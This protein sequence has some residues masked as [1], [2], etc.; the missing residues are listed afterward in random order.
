MP[1]GRRVMVTSELIPK[2][3]WL[4]PLSADR[5]RSSLLAPGNSSAM[6]GAPCWPREAAPRQWDNLAE[7]SPL[8]S[9]SAGHEFINTVSPAHVLSDKHRTRRGVIPS[10][11]PL[12]FLSAEILKR[13]SGKV[14]SLLWSPPR[15]FWLSASSCSQL[16]PQ[17]YYKTNEHRPSRGCEPPG[18]R[19]C[20]QSTLLAWPA[21]CWTQLVT[22]QTK[23]RNNTKQGHPNHAPFCMTWTTKLIPSSLD[24]NCRS[25]SWLM[26]ECGQL[27]H[28]H[29]SDRSVW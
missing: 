18:S 29:I 25:A 26:A 15:A 14:I 20:A 21:Q 28:A 27:P 5:Y 3:R 19:V 13:K 7:V 16:W 12:P 1:S 6:A 9:Y 23:E 8:L 2:Q 11:S 4:S 17:L 10:Q 24:C 22:K